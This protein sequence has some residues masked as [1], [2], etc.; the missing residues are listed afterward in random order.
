MDDGEPS[1]N[2]SIVI[3]HQYDAMD[4]FDSLFFQNMILQ[5]EIITCNRESLTTS[6]VQERGGSN[7]KPKRTSKT[8]IAIG[9]PEVSLN[10]CSTS[11]RLETSLKYHFTSSYTISTETS[12]NYH[13]RSSTG[14]SLNCH[15]DRNVAKL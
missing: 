9:I 6:K 11:C 3:T 5:K 12:V 15:I 8:I 7:K 1:A 13:C 10:Y 4:N 14:I 2:P